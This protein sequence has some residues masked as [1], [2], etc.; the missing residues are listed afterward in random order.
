MVKQIVISRETIKRNIIT[1]L[2]ENAEMQLYCSSCLSF[3]IELATIKKTKDC[4]QML[5]ICKDCRTRI[6]VEI[7]KNLEINQK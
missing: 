6:P 3:R 4:I 1:Q 7:N 5:F 2:E